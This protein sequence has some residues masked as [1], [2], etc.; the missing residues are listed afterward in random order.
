MLLAETVDRTG[1]HP[2]RRLALPDSLAGPRVGRRPRL[3]R[4][5]LSAML[6]GLA[7]L[8]AAGSP[9]FAHARLQSSNPP[10]GGV[11]AVAPSRVALTFG[12]GVESSADAIQVFDD[13]LRRVRTGPVAVG[14]ASSDQLSVTVPGRLAGGTYTVSWRVS[15]GDTHPVSGSFR[16]SIGAPSV[17]TG[18]VPE[19]GR[20]NLAGLILGVM[21]GAGYVGL[22]LGPG[23]LLVVLLLWRPGLGDNG[24]RRLLYVG[25]TLLAASTV[26]EMLLQGVWVSG[27]AISAIWSSPGALGTGSRTF[28]QVHA[29]RLY[30][31]MAFGITLA[32]TLA[33]QRR[34][35]PP[36]VASR[37]LPSAAPLTSGLGRTGRV[38]LAVAPLAV[39]VPPARALALS[40]VPAP[41]LPAPD[42]AVPAPAGSPSARVPARVAVAVAGTALMAT[43]ALVGHAAAGEAVP[44]AIAANL[45]HVLAMSLWLGGLALIAVILRPGQ[46]SADLSLDLVTVLPQFSRLA[47]GC[48]A[49]LAATGGLMA[50]RE[51]GSL[52]ALISTEYGRVLLVKLLAVAVLLAL[53][54]VARRWV[55]RHLPSP[56][57]LLSRPASPGVQPATAMIFPP[58]YGDPEVRRLRQGVLA[59]I[60]VAAAV[61]T[62]TAALVVIVPAR[63]DYVRPFH[64]VLLAPAP[65]V[66]VVLDIPAPR[67][68]DA[69]LNVTVT[70]TDG[71]PQ[72]VTA[73]TGSVSLV[74]PRMGPLPLRPGPAAAPSGSKTLAVSFPAKGTWTL[75]LSVQTT[76]TDATAFSTEVP[77]S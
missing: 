53:G 23:L 18:V 5:V 15:S 65:D 26:S 20:N 57:H 39:S 44:L 43:W 70:T 50:V 25:L 66:K 34:G 17:V 63:Q 12:E 47:F 73:L 32:A 61:L 62:L 1:P 55:H 67:Q 72:P 36:S 48:V 29:V 13:H 51:V 35:P 59:E 40:D 27:R 30:L 52:E 71:R 4:R 60:L 2:W 21:R 75:R 42:L 8:V 16:F 19:V 24:I 58:D 10:A 38:T 9:A 56:P 74:S 31:L 77:V 41:G 6:V 54:N 33:G 46:R 45:A 22:A 68:G 64:R 28:D 3:L 7:L 11:L 37:P 76:P 49:T 14:G 69:V